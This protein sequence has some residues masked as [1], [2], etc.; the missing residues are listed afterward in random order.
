[1]TSVML[2]CD[3]PTLLHGVPTCQT[4]NM[5]AI[6]ARGLTKTFGKVTAV[7]GI[8]FHVA[9]GA[10]V[11]LLGPNGAGKTTTLDM[12]LGLTK[13]SSGELH[14]LGGSPGEAIRAGR[15]SA[16]LQTGGLL[17]DMTVSETVR[18]VAAAYKDPAP[19]EEVLERTGLRTLAGRR[20]SK[21]SGGEQQRL[22]FALALLAEP[23]I[24]ILDEPTTGMDVGARR[25][26]WATMHA[27]AT[28]GRTVIFATHYLQEAE[29]FADRIIL[30]SEGKIVADGEME[31]V[32]AIAGMRHVRAK[33]GGGPARADELVSAVLAA[34]PGTA[35]AF[36]GDTL[37]ITTP[38]SDD[39]ARLVLAEPDVFDV[40]ITDSSLEDAFLSLTVDTHHT[41]DPAD[42]NGDRS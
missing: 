6:E 40:T 23:D 37:H 4:F 21:C 1:M 32:R 42:V 27:E 34:I 24:L 12:L 30:M 18:Y 3:D 20:V 38:N 16:L 8:D 25:S 14:V 41:T 10:V 7:D 28:D 31:D 13:P 17:A 36:D 2:K 5:F 39:A 9:R 29:E 11:A 15:I 35:A 19:I 22:K 33:L 26:F